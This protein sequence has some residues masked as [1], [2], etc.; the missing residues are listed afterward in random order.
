LAWPAFRDD[1]GADS[2]VDD[3][4]GVLGGTDDAGGLLGGALGGALLGCAVG[5]VDGAVWGAGV[6]RGGALSPPPCHDSAT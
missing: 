3:A 1:R 6:T 4:D 2:P 5:E